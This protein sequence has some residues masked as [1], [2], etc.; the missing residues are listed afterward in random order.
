MN[1]LEKEYQEI[2]ALMLVTLGIVIGILTLV[3]FG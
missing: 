3:S 1:D 2:K